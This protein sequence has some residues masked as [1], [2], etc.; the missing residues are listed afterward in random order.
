MEA[1]RAVMGRKR[2]LDDDDER[3][4]SPR[5]SSESEKISPRLLDAQVGLPTPVVGHVGIAGAGC[6]RGRVTGAVKSRR[7][8]QDLGESP[9]QFVAK[10]TALSGP[11]SPALRAFMGDTEAARTPTAFVG[12]PFELKKAAGGLVRPMFPLGVQGQGRPVIPTPLGTPVRVPEQKTSPPGHLRRLDGGIA[13]RSGGPGVSPMGSQEQKSPVLQ[14]RAMKPLLMKA[15]SGEIPLADRGLPTISQFLGSG[16][17]DNNN[18]PA[19]GSLTTPYRV[20]T[21]AS[22]TA[23]SSKQ[24]TKRQPFPFPQRRNLEPAKGISTPVLDSG[25]MMNSISNPPMPSFEVDD[26][27]SDEELMSIPGPDIPDPEV[28][29]S[30]EKLGD[31]SVTENNLEDTVVLTLCDGLANSLSKAERDR[32]ELLNLHTIALGQQP[33]P[34]MLGRDQFQDIFGD[35]IRGGMLSHL[36][37]RHCLIHVENMP[38]QNDSAKMGVKVRVEDTS[39]NGIRVNGVLLKNGQTME[40]DLDDVVTL[41]RIRRDEDDVSL[42][43]KLVRSDPPPEKASRSSKKSRHDGRYVRPSDKFF[44]ELV[45][46]SNRYG[47]SPVQESNDV[48]PVTVPAGTIAHEIRHQIPSGPFVPGDPPVLAGKD[49]KTSESEPVR[50][51]PTLTR[52]IRCTILFA[53]QSTQ[54]FSESSQPL[55][56]MNFDYREELSEVLSTFAVRT[57]DASSYHCATAESIQQALNGSSDVLFYTGGGGEDHLVVEAPN[58]LSARLEKDEVRQLFSEVKPNATKLVVVITPTVE[59][60]HLLAECGATHVCFLSSASKHSLRVT[61]F[62]R[63][64]FAGLLKSFS[65][66]KSYALAEY[67]ALNDLLPIVRP[68]DQICKMLPISAQLNVQ[69]GSL[70]TEV[71]ATDKNVVG[72]LNA[73]FIPVLA[74]H[75]LGRD[76]IVRK[77][78]AGLARKVRVCNIYGARG[79]GKSSIAIHIAKMA[80]RTRGYRNG[81]HYFAVDKL[82]EHIQSAHRPETDSEDQDFQSTNQRE[83]PLPVVI[84]GVET[85]LRSLPEMENADYPATLLVLDGCDIV[86]PA[87]GM[88]VLNIVQAFPSVQILLTSTKEVQIDTGEDSILP[89]EVVHVGELG[90]LDSAKLFFKLA[91]GH[92]TSRQFRQHFPDS[93]IE[94]ISNDERLLSTKG[95]PFRISRLVYELESQTVSGSN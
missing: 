9:A 38:S 18:S 13:A 79:V 88:F 74:T 90:K 62:I 47:L 53:D 16:G 68:A 56:E 71:V 57:F 44:S 87:L 2:A 59:P 39:T 61:A 66:E 85:L 93:S 31:L 3:R 95:N 72:V 36:S 81:V 34:I 8:S 63:A 92:L 20:P 86:L 51:M 49:L 41:L 12:S 22:T 29:F 91:R 17:Q 64:L 40:L 14:A 30:Q 46:V 27:S 10:I 37:R 43:Y 45:D 94:V 67:V 75:F 21:V 4:D 1:P 23:P 48:P 26:V 82:V 58:G 73:P 5:A 89:E 15:G 54:D 69:L 28:S 7:L 24:V 65:I 70:D 80:Y 55:E 25:G 76:T 6:E 33:S 42:E 11:A 32:M 84:E 19:F 50:Q 83:D 52:K 35:N 78:K 60:A 77:V